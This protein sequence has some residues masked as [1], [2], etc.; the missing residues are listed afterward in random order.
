MDLDKE[1]EKQRL[2]LDLQEK[3]VYCMCIVCNKEIYVGEECKYDETTREY[4]HENCLDDYL[5]NFIK[6]K[7][8]GEE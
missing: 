1:L 6:S 8:A 2:K 4:I 3:P 7:V 5:I